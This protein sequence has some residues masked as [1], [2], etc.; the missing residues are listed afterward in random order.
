MKNIPQVNFIYWLLMIIATTTGEIVGNYISRD[1]ELGY[2]VG[3]IILVSLFCVAIFYKI[4]YKKVNLLYYWVLIILG[5]IAGTNV[6]DLICIQLDLGTVYGS[7]LVVLILFFVLIGIH[8]LSKSKN[9]FTEMK[10]EFLYWLAI[11]FSSTFGTT[12]G[13][14]LSNDTPLGAAGGTILLVMPF[15]VFVGLLLLKKIS[16]EVFYWITIILIHPIGATF[17]N[18]IS[19]P[20][21]LD[22]GNV[23]TSI[24]LVGLF[25]IIY[26]I[27]NQDKEI[28]Q[29]HF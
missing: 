21:G 15:F 25:S 23:Y 12:S 1:L 3:S 9:P 8:F 20:Q 13:D 29:V 22:L 11:L 24:F 26:F 16:K 4:L 10:V 14:F 28:V 2:K 6:A 7:I 5:N 17:G 27:T 18:Y 19:K